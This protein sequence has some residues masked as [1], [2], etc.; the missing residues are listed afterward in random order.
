VTD[1]DGERDLIVCDGPG[2]S[3]PIPIAWPCTRN[4]ITE[5][6]DSKNRRE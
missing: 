4:D 3:A 5:P 2:G 1:D 6:G